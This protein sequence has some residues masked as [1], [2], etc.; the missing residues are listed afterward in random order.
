MYG[1]PDKYLY[2]YSTSEAAFQHILPARLLR[3]SPL[4]RLRDPVEN[5]EWV[6][7]M[8]TGSSWSEKEVTEFKR[9][10][11]RVIHE[12]RVLSF[13]RDASSVGRPPEHAR[14]YARPRMW[15]Q[16][17]ANHEGVCMIFDREHLEV[18]LTRGL[19]AYGPVVLG[20]VIYSDRPLE[21]HERARRLDGSNLKVKGAGKL[22]RG[23]SEHLKQH[24]LEL[25][26]RKLDDWKSENEYR[27]VVI[28]KTDKDVLV[29]YGQALSAVVVGER[30]PPWQMP[31][32]ERLC[33]EVGV[34]LRQ[35]RWG[36]APPQIVDPTGQ[37]GDVGQLPERWKVRA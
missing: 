15:E 36:A 34:K 11:A 12:A 33:N 19:S 22:E 35:I 31:G 30:F 3:L 26:F 24:A 23:L 10:V 9:L 32:A 37:K 25:F 20:D 6:Q 17:G 21:G 14:G 2:H 1:E 7:V 28:S 4:A 5:K 16:Y 27:Y 18:S 13:T 8:L 29:D